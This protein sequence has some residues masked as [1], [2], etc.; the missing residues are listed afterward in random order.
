MMRYFTILFIFTFFDDV[1]AQV[2]LTIC[3]KC[4]TNEVFIGGHEEIK[5]VYNTDSCISYYFDN[6]E[7]EYLFLAFGAD[8]A[9]RERLWIDPRYHN[10]TIQINNCTHHLTTFDTLSIER[11][12]MACSEIYTAL[13]NATNPEKGDSLLELWQQC[14]ERY[15]SAHPDSFLA[16]YYLRSILGSMDLSKAIR[17]RD[18]L[19]KSNANFPTFIDIDKSIASR[20]YKGIPLVGDSFMEFLS[21]TLSGQIFDSRTVKNKTILLY[22]WFAGCEPCK[23]MSKPLKELYNK[24]RAEGLE[25]ISVSIDNESEC[26]KSS[27]ERNYPWISIRAPEGEYD[28]LPN[29]YNVTAYPSFV[30]FDKN[31]KINMLTWGDEM[32]LIEAK[33]KELLLK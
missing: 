18:I 21:P 4:Y 32:L 15:I 29:H 11:D 8:R 26:I 31:K 19:K 14:E 6:K 13:E 1:S 20:K 16:V 10:R 5:G 9:Y 17:Y 2:K 7:P 22:F 12:D 28:V 23:K 3:Q 33:I 30:L 27:L 24:Y 25:I